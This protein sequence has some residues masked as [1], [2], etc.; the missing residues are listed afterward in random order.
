MFKATHKRRATTLSKTLLTAGL[1]GGAALS[2]LGAGS[3]QAAGGSFD[4]SFGNSI[5]HTACS[6]INW[7][8]GWI[9]EDK[10]LT[11]LT[12]FPGIGPADAPPSG[13]F[14]FVYDDF[15][16]SG[17]SVEDRWT[18]LATFDPAIGPP[19]TGSYSYNLAITKPGWYFNDVELDSEHAGSGTKATKVVEVVGSPDVTLESINGIPD[20][21]KSIY[22]ATFIHVT[23]A[24]DIDSTTG[25]ISSIS[26]TYSQVPAPLP[27]LG[28]GAAF[29]SIRKL[30]K[31][32]SQ[33]KTFS[34][35]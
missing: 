3:A 14:S 26:N 5:A 13:T 23:D 16:A 8:T 29:G 17:L 12:Y 15:G 19:P 27:L 2:T 34:M 18:T 1:L 9:L 10:K 6:A 21:P 33:L 7:A 24:W 25:T 4:C 35:G 28:A 31:F 30:R 20:G 32:S 11:N 22:P